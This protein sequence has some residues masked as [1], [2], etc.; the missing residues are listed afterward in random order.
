ME[1]FTAPRDSA[2]PRLRA[3]FDSL[4]SPPGFTI[5]LVDVGDAHL[6]RCRTARWPDDAN[7]RG[8]GGFQT[9]KWME[10]SC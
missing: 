9:L 1:T 4:R 7:L 5:N 8:N 6:R 3:R 2:M 10:L